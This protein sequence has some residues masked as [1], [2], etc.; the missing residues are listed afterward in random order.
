MRYKSLIIALFVIFAIRNADAVSLK[1]NIINATKGEPVASYPVTVKIT[2]D[3][4]H[5]NAGVVETLEFQTGADGIFKGNI[6]V[7]TGKKIIAQ[8]NYRG[9]NYYSEA[10]EVTTGNEKMVFKVPV[11]DISD[12]KEDIAILERHVSLIPTNEKLIQVFDTLKIENAG[13]KTYVGKFND[14][15]DI[16]QV[17]YIPM[18]RG[19]MLAQLGGISSSKISTFSGGIVSRQEI[20]PGIHQVIFQYNV[21][22]ETGFFDL[23]L[24]S[25]MDSPEIQSLFLYFPKGDRW[26]IKISDLK[27]SGEQ[28]FGTRTFTMWGGI[29]GSV[30]KIKVYGP[31]YKGVKSFGSIS[32]IL[33]F[34]ASLTG[35]YLLRRSIRL[36]H[37]KREKKRLESVLTGLKNENISGSY[38]PFVRIVT[39]RLKEI[40]QRLGT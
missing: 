37:I 5:K 15:L 38:E 23:S 8:V 6:D 13:N 19:Y 27:P 14:E 3:D 7:K 9:I 16:T 35:L 12:K 39:G 20:K 40:D 32:I 21:L 26:K 1:V 24:F 17:L 25:R 31:T 10:G 33:T 2:D 28:Q 11:Y 34:A 36:W 30:V 22:S 4:F 29:A 18:P